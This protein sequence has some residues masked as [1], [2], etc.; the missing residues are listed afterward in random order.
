MSQTVYL[1]YP[2]RDRLYVDLLC[3]DINQHMHGAVAG[4][5]IDHL[6][7]PHPLPHVRIKVQDLSTFLAWLA[8]KI[9]H[10]SLLYQQQGPCW[11][12]RQLQMDVSNLF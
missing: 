9:Q 8:P 10:C 12:G 11:L 3:D 7:S 1:Y 5:L 6:Q 2:L 4:D